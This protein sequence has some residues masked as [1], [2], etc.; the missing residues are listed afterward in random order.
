MLVE[1]IDDLCLAFANTQ[2]KYPFNTE[3]IVILPDHLHTIWVLPENDHDYPSRWQAI[4]SH[5]TR[6][7][8]KHGISIHKNKRG[9]YDLWQRRYWEHTIR[10]ECDLKTHIDYI[11]YNPIKHGLVKRVSDWPHSSFHRFVRGGLLPSDWGD[12]PRAFKDIEYGE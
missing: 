7:L 8:K 6:G 9:E 12:V 3:A 5:F 4:K 11:H 10:D 1:H 2:I